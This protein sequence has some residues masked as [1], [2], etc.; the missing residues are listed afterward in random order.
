MG[1]GTAFAGFEF[2]EPVRA[3][4]HRVNTAVTARRSVR[5]LR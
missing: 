4:L 1:H 5:S 2:E 3:I